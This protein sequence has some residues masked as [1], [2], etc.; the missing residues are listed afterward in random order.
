MTASNRYVL[1]LDIDGKDPRT[2]FEVT[3]R[4]GM[5]RRFASI[6]S[7]KVKETETAHGRHVQLTMFTRATYS[8]SDICFFQLFLGSDARRELFNWY[9]V[10]NGCKRWNVLFKRK[11]RW[12]MTQT[13]REERPL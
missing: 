1:K 6:S 2:L 12:D 8:D 11:Y 5:L 9:R 10:R 4:M 7:Y 3:N 13:S